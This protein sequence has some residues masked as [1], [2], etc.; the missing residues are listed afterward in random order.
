MLLSLSVGENR[1]PILPLISSNSNVVL[2]RSGANLCLLVAFE[3]LAVRD[4]QSVRFNGK[5]DSLR[6]M[7][8]FILIPYLKQTNKKLFLSVPLWLPLV[9]SV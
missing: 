4:G 2:P 3:L 7:L 1:K 5:I 8:A 9:P 6:N